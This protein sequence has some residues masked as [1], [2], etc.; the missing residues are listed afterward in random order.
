MILS[1]RTV[2]DAIGITIIISNCAPTSVAIPGTTQ[3]PPREHIGAPTQN[4][5]MPQRIAETGQYVISDST[6]ISINGDSSHISSFQTTTLYSLSLIPLADSFSV[7][8]KVDST[9]TYPRSSAGAYGAERSSHDITHATISSTGQLSALTGEIVSSCQGGVDAMATRV[10]ELAQNYSKQHMRIGDKWA[11]TVFAVNCRGKTPLHQQI[12]RE[13][14]LLELATWKEHQI[15]K[16]QR[17]ASSTVLGNS[18]DPHNYLNAVGTGIGKA[19]LYVDRASG[20]LLESDGRSE[21]T[22]TIKTSRGS[23]P[24]RQSMRTHIELR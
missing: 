24:F 20:F 17:T 5:W 10:F 1:R 14:E 23:Y 13:Y 8:A 3:L 12:I 2:L 16:I 22:L 11:D 21:T 15:A 9:T 6:S 4:E 18:P 7:T 19:I